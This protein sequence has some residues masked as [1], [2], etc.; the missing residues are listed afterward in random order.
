MTAAPQPA[1]TRRPLATGV[2]AAFVA[3]KLALHLLVLAV[4]PYGMQ[5]DAFLYFAMGDHL[6]FWRMDFPPFIALMANLQTALFGHTMAAARVFPAIE[7][8]IILVLAAMIARELGGGAFAQ[9][10]AALG[11]L[12]GGIFLRP[13]TLFQPVVL[14]QLW[15]TLSLY[16]LIRVGRA[17]SRREARAQRNWWLA[18]GVATGLGLLTKFSIL[19]LGLAVLAALVATPLRRS[20]RTPW[21]WLAG[22][23]AFA[24]GSPSIVGQIVLGYPVVGQMHE[25]AAQQLSHV[26]WLSF[27][28]AQPFMVG[29]AAW[30]LAVA[31]AA[32]LVAWAPL[33]AYRAA[34][35]AC[36][37]AFLLL[38]GLHGKAYYIG[39]IYPTLLAAGA[40]WLERLGAEPAPRVRPAF[41]WAVVALIAAQGLIG[42][43]V[44]L[45]LL[46]RAETARYIVAVGAEWALG[47]NWGGADLLP[48]DFAD[49]TGWRHQ[50]QTLARVYHALPPA[51]Q[52]Q[53]VIGA[54]NYGEAGAA[55]FYAGEYGLPPAVCGCGSYWFFGPGVRPGTVLIAIGD[56]SSNVAQIYG[57]VRRAARVLSPWSV[58]E[59]R[60]VPVYVARA[61]K[62]TLQRVWPRIRDEP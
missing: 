8:T 50:A 47:T 45:P 58:Q 30:V 22:V 61:P 36:V 11:V 29:F 31:G 59:E 9:G 42:L 57:Q 49:Q 16:A 1:E 38:L 15:W 4:S 3:G 14:D 46:P 37:F 54:S 53:A 52:A 33:R 6:R 43:P 56:D 25:L 24:I 20:L 55:E 48:Q 19:F 41:R 32:A 35:W 5:R 7:G 17:A 2:I 62:M 10:L 23:V 28:V 60:D 34:G 40:V 18:F 27:V 12:T 13:S 26:S 51:E 44:A 21:P 39:P